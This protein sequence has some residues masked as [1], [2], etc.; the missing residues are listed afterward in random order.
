MDID[1]LEAINDVYGHL[2]GDAVLQACGQR[3]LACMRPRDFVA[4][5]GGDEFVAVI[6]DV[7]SGDQAELIA[8][9]IRGA[10]GEPIDVA[11]RQLQ[12]SVSIGV[13]VGD[14]SSS[15]RLLLNEAD[16]AMYRA[17]LRHTANLRS[18]KR[19]DV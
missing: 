5:Y 6:G 4:R 14:A 3:L 18:N 7:I 9:R 10:L 2:A 17:K 15:D 12:V 11:G 19:G 1:K 16:Q 13:A 8:E